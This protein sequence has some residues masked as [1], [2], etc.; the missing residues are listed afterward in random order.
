MR[1]LYTLVL[2]IWCAAPSRWRWFRWG[3]GSMRTTQRTKGTAAETELCHMPGEELAITQRA[4]E[5]AKDAKQ[6]CACVRQAL[7]AM[8]FLK[9]DGVEQ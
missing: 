9:S 1:A 4:L 3:G 6:A 5:G 2:R 7:D 8:A